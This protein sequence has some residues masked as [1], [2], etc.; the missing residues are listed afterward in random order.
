MGL[1]KPLLI[2]TCIVIW[3][4]HTHTHAQTSRTWF[5]KA[6]T[7]RHTQTVACAAKSASVRCLS[8]CILWDRLL[9]FVGAG[10][11]SLINAIR[12][13]RHRV[14]DEQRLDE[15][16]YGGPIR[17]PSSVTAQVTQPSP[18]KVTQLPTTEGDPT[19]LAV[20]DLSR[21]GRG[22]HTTTTTSLIRL[23]GGGRLADT[24]GFGLPSLEGIRSTVS[25]D[26]HMQ[27]TYLCS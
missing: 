12:L 24:P 23:P 17:L 2:D 4:T 14:D 5:G 27:H 3:H 21:S 19:Y 26:I 6:D 25:D 15:R 20:G 10:K 16:F 9:H 22:R 1:H 8:L 11:S 13:G 7:H 18:A